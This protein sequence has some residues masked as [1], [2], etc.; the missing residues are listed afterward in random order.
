[1]KEY[2]LFFSCLQEIRGKYEEICDKF[3]G[4]CRK[5]VGICEKYKEICGN[6]K[7]MKKYEALRPRGASCY[8]IEV[9]PYINVLGLEKTPSSPSV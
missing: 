1:M 4:M 7:N 8:N 6:V 2:D 5:Y 9:S 3:E